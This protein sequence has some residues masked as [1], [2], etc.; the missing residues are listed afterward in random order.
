MSKHRFLVL[1][2]HS[3]GVIA[4]AQQN[5]VQLEIVEAN[6]SSKKYNIDWPYQG[7][8]PTGS[9]ADVLAKVDTIL[10][11]NN[12]DCPPKREKISDNIWRCGNGKEIRTKDKRLV[13]LLTKAWD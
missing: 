4:Y 12:I 11:E 7:P 13:R 6:G 8:P 1:L 10:L 2:L 3:L 9:S 5:K